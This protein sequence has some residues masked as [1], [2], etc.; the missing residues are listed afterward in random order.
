MTLYTQCNITVV[1]QFRRYQGGCPE[2]SRDR[3]VLPPDLSVL[4]NLG[5]LMF[6]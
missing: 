3:D 6:G 1:C 5:Q 2:S 4:I